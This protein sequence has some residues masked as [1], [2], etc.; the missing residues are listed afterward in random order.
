MKKVIL[1]FAAA[2]CSVLMM[3]QTNQ[4]TWVNGRAVL[5]QSISSIDSIKYGIIE[6]ADQLV[7]WLP[8]TIIVHDTVIVHD[9]IIIN[10]C[11]SSHAPEGIEMV[12]LGLP[13]GIKWANMN[14]G[15][16][17][18]EGYGDY[19]AWGETEPKEVYDW[20]TYFDTNDGGSTLIKYN[21]NGGKTTL[22]PEDDAAHVNW[23]GNWRMPTKAEQDELRNT[24]NC[25]WEWKTN[26]NGTGVNGY[27]VTSKKNGNSIFLPA[28]GCRF[29][30]SVSDVGSYGY[31]WS[32]SLFEDYSYYAYYFYFYSVNVDWY[33]NNRYYGRSVRPVCQ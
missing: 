19:F 12:D 1:F 21:N 30:S 31:Y 11:D 7:L 6:D 2:V 27:L 17:T 23:G 29:V 28:S 32:S 4:V 16:T 10:K 26:Y 20:S 15:A 22:D 18:P 5:G 3:A 24:D 13:S 14:V 25:T 33:Y 9:T 8:K